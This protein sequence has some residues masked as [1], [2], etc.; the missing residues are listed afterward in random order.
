MDKE[1]ETMFL[2]E[3]YS[4]ASYKGGASYKG[5]G[6]EFYEKVETKLDGEKKKVTYILQTSDT[7][8][9]TS[10]DGIESTS[11]DS[12]CHS[13]LKKESINK[14][15]RTKLILASVLCLLFMTGEMVGGLLAHSLAIVSDAAHLLTDFASFMISLM[16]LYL[17]HRPATKKL[18]F[19]W[20]RVEILGA[21]LSILMLWVLTGVLVYSAVL[22]IMEDNYEIDA[23]IMLITAATGVAFNI[24]L[25]TTLHQHS[26]SHGGG[27]GHS[28]E[29]EGHG[30]SH[31][32]KGHGHSHE[33]GGHSHLHESGGHGHSH[34]SQGHG[35]S[36]ENGGH[37]HLHESGGH[38]HSHK[39]HDGE[40]DSRRLSQSASKTGSYGAM[41][42]VEAGSK[43][44]ETAPL[45]SG[46]VVE[47]K[48]HHSGSNINVKA[49]FIHVIG[50]LFQSV[51]VLVAAF[52]IYYKPE[53]KIADPICTFMF[54]LFVLV[55]T[56]TIMRD[57][58][59]VLME[60]TPRGINFAEVRETFFE[61]E[62]VLDIHNL[63]VWSLTMDKTALS[64]HLAV[65][66]KSDPLRVLKMASQAIQRR[67]NI[68]ETTM[69]I[70]EYVT[71]MDE[72]Q[73]CQGPK[74]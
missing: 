18:S 16:A 74:L 64:V 12:H 14:K 57:I 67:F 24:V 9:Q 50:D 71:E 28:H 25:G 63:R 38:S 21:F 41:A 53:W 61:V 11:N 26:H 7:H 65:D 3:S 20:Y 68:S 72:C 39:S 73:E 47:K 23:T 42:D 58:I 17:A 13:Q 66:K 49:A 43:E 29:S 69:Q 45:L 46:K 1:K 70:E 30:H 22:R 4:S 27:H 19:G 34:E 40:G 44:D 55:T 5:N 15:A 10:T 62:G 2:S 52:I 37:S 31:E 33:N 56:L 60:G 35:R 36:H 48:S 8:H 32:S 6:G 54:S 51:G 59:V